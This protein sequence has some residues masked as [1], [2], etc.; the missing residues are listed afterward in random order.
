RVYGEHEFGVPPLDLPPSASAGVEAL[1]HYEG[2]ALFIERA[3]AVRS[4]FQV[5]NANA[6]A[7]AMICARLDGL[8]LA[9][10]LAAARIRLLRQEDV[11]GQPRFRMLETIREFALE[12]LGRSDEEAGIRR[13]HAAAYLALVRRAEP[14]LQ[15]KDQNRWLDMLEREHDNVRAALSW[16]IEQGDAA[17]AV[18]IASAFWRFWHMRGHLVEGASRMTTLL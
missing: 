9:I 12:Q 7:V 16:T 2:V 17:T 3:V 18:A 11:G 10:E 6:P 14:E 13:R 15:G 1:T 4:D 8:P 5:T